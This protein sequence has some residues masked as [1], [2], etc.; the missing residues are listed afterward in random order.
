MPNDSNRISSINSENIS[1]IGMVTFLDVLG[2]KGIYKNDNKA[3]EKLNNIITK[4]KEASENNI[5]EHVLNFDNIN[6]IK[7]KV[8]SI[9]DTIVIIS[10]F[11][12][13]KGK[14]SLTKI[15]KYILLSLYIH[16]KIC[17][18]AIREGI[19]NNIYLRGATS[20]GKFENKNSIFL[21]EAIDEAADWHE[22]TD[23]IGVILSPTS[24][25]YYR[26]LQYNLRNLRKNY[27]YDDVYEELKNWIHYD[28]VPLKDKKYSLNVCLNWLN[29]EI[30]L[31]KDKDM[32]FAN[33][34]SL[35]KDIASKYLNTFD[36]IEYIIKERN[37]MDQKNS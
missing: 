27:A 34:G 21:G 12:D 20:L 32:I 18:E 36:F 15:P 16:S 17:G 30:Y 25:M 23:W 35:T 22:Q 10:Y 6:K 33:V 31:V 1:G 9:S 28:K 2:W 13:Y 7:I 14:K 5:P 37:K 26:I 3:I 24:S 29:N 4:I 8:L 11:D 19:N